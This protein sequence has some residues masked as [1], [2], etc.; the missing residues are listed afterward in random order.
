[1]LQ[2]PSSTFVTQRRQGLQAPF[3]GP[4]IPPCPYLPTQP[5]TRPNRGGFFWPPGD[6]ALFVNGIV[7]PALGE[8]AFLLSALRPLGRK[9]GS[10]LPP[11]S[12]VVRRRRVRQSRTG[13]LLAP[14]S[15]GKSI[16]PAMEL[17]EIH[18]SLIVAVFNNF[19]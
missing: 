10:G 11:G 1:M 4:R 5:L 14:P 18:R 6:G 19:P 3:G 9:S 16:S 13:A 12:P 15:G 2:R 7:I 8:C 17:C